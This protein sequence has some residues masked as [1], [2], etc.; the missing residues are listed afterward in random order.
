MTVKKNKNGSLVAIVDRFCAG[1][2]IIQGKFPVPTG[3]AHTG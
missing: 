1:L 3:N 2:K